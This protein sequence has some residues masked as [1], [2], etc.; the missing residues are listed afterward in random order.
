MVFRDFLGE[1]MFAKY[2]HKANYILGYQSC[3]TDL[4]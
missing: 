1:E 4:F 3:L 2:L